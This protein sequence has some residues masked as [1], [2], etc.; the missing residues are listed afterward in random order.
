MKLFIVLEKNVKEAIEDLE[1]ALGDID[2]ILDS[3]LGV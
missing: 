3:I 2:S 1:V